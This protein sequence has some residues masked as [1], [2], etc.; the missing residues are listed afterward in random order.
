[1]IPSCDHGG[2]EESASA[3]LLHH[4]RQRTPIIVLLPC[5]YSVTDR[6]TPLKRLEN[7]ILD[8]IVSGDISCKPPPVYAQRFVQFTNAALGGDNATLRANTEHRLAASRRP[9]GILLQGEYGRKDIPRSLWTRVG[10]VL[11]IIA[12]FALCAR[13]LQLHNLVLLKHF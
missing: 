13:R 5:L 9:L 6:Y 7:F 2:A 3:L 12:I 8:P 4:E 10:S 1:M 11:G